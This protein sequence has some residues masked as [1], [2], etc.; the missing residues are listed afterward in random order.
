MPVNY[1]IDRERGL[2]MTIGEGVVTWAEFTAHVQKLRMDPAFHPGLREVLDTIHVSAVDFSARELG[3]FFQQGKDPYGS[4]SWRAVVAPDDRF[5]A[6]AK[7]YQM[8]MAVTRDKHFEVFRTR[9]EAYRW[10]GVEDGSP[11]K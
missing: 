2:V 11:P 9:E 7:M 8:W 10:L 3:T 1:Q 6:L 5:Y 4:G